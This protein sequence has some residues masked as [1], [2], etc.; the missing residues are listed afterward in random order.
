MG[1]GP[2]NP[3]YYDFERYSSSRV[4]HLTYWLSWR[5]CK[6]LRAFLLAS[7]GAV[8]S[9]YRPRFF[10]KIIMLS[11]SPRYLKDEDY[12]GGFEHED[13]DQ[14]FDAMIENYHSWCYG[15]APLWIGADMDSLV[16]QEFSRTLFSMRSDIALNQMNT[17]FHSD[18]RPILGLVSAPCHIIQ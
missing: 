9:S 18:L 17:T 2:T 3:E 14:L 1:A 8:A 7:I 6:L 13:F 4:M 12:F 15:F 5:S 10:S 11:A 16:M